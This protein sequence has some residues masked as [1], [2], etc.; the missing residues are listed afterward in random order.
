MHASHRHPAIMP[1]P[2][3]SSLKYYCSIKCKG[4]LCSDLSATGTSMPASP[5][6]SPAWAEESAAVSGEAAPSVVSRPAVVRSPGAAAPLAVSWGAIPAAAGSVWP[7]S[8]KRPL[9]TA[10][11]FIY[12]H[13]N[14]SVK[15]T[16]QFKTILYCPAACVR[17]ELI[18]T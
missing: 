14:S 15:E 6:P 13:L 11:R 12:L 9:D 16:R 18:L 17:L 2:P 10:T 8:K 5:P 7:S 1:S 3:V 4:R